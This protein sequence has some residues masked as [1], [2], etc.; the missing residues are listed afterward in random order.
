MHTTIASDSYGDIGPIMPIIM[1][2]DSRIAS[3]IADVLKDIPV[4]VETDPL[5]QIIKGEYVFGR[6]SRVILSDGT[7]LIPY[8]IQDPLLEGRF[9][10]LLPESSNHMIE[11]LRVGY[12]NGFSKENVEGAHKTAQMFNIPV[13]QGST[14][15]E[16]GNCFMTQKGAIVGIHSV[17]LSLIALEEQKFFNEEIIAKNLSGMEIPGPLYLRMARNYALYAEKLLI[18]A[19]KA[20]GGESGF[21]KRLI[22]PL[23]ELEIKEHCTAAK[24]WKMKWDFTLDWM[25][26]ELG[27]MKENLAVLH[28]NEFH[29]DMEMALAPDQ[30]LFIHDPKQAESITENLTKHKKQRQAESSHYYDSLHKFSRVHC[31]REMRTL[32][33]NLSRLKSLGLTVIQIPAVYGN[34][35]ERINFING[36]FLQN[37]EELFFLTNGAKRKANALVDEFSQILEKHN[38]KPIYFD[39]LQQVLSRNHG[40]LHCLTWTRPS[41]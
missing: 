33:N 10:V 37:K 31:E 13:K 20:I 23:T 4:R 12:G 40:G 6:D 9:K 15:I 39:E 18:E 7:H 29:L 1:V 14:C 38:I 25:A 5:C 27:V 24:I 34:E 21:R 30:R 8:P 11:S 22:T 35:S 17:I 32:D 26:K 19:S 3:I 2:G 16:G 28:Q 36:L 41:M